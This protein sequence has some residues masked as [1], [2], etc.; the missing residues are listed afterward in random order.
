MCEVA[1]H[2]CCVFVWTFGLDWYSLL[3]DG[4][5]LKLFSGGCASIKTLNVTCPGSMDNIKLN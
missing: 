2:G 1:L 5:M 4:V 3:L